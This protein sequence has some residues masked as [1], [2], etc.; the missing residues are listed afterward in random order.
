MIPWTEPEN[1]LAEDIARK[2]DCDSKLDS[3]GC[4]FEET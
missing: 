3:L 2:A 1:W 4:S